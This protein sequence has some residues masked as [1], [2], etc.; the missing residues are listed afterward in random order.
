MSSRTI[1]GNIHFRILGLLFENRYC[2]NIK[3]QDECLYSVKDYRVQNS[4][5]S[6][7]YNLSYHNERTTTTAPL[8]EMTAKFVWSYKNLILKFKYTYKT[9]TK[10]HKNVIFI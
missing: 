6:F 10:V 8:H 2:Y 5:G 4:E 7:K 9:N 3:N 1:N